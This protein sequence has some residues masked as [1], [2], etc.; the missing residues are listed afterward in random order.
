MLSTI[1]LCI[2]YRVRVWFRVS[3]WV[4]GNCPRTNINIDTDR[5]E[6][7]FSNAFSKYLF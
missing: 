4:G 7:I 2:Q 6:W 3:F 1:S 5:S